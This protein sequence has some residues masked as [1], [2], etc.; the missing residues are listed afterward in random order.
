MVIPYSACVG[1]ILPWLEWNHVFAC[2]LDLYDAFSSLILPA[3][4]PCCKK[5]KKK[6]IGRGA[7]N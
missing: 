5:K 4:S 3:P 2:L 7:Y 6:K 1:Q